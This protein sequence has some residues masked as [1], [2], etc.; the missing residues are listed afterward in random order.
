[1]KLTVTDLKIVQTK[2][3]MLPYKADAERYGCPEFWEAIDESGGDCDDFAIAKLQRLK[4]MGM[5]ISQMRLA[6]CWAL[7]HQQGYHC[8]LLVD[9]DG[10]TWVLDNRYPLPMEYD[11]LPYEW[12]KLQIAGTMNWEKAA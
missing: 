10:T 6:T 11:L 9:L 5:P 3:N 8:V 12:D 1:M 2:V 7:P 4:A